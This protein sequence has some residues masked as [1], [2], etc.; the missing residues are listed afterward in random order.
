MSMEEWRNIPGYEDY[1]ISSFGHVRRNGK[2]LKPTLT[3][4]GYYRISLC[5]SIKKDYRIHR[6]V[7][8]AFIPNPENKLDVDHKDGN[9]LNNKL[10]N[11]RWATRSENLLNPNMLR[12][13][14]VLGE[15]YISY[16]GTAFGVK[17]QRIKQVVYRKVFPTL[18]EAIEARDNFLARN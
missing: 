7:A 10:D 2:V 1:Q 8:L 17:I 16:T 3:T 9:R 13:P 5:R 6:L 18:R 12:Y 15:K 11:L 14:G 4:T